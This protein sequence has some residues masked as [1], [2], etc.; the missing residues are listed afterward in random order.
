MKEQETT[1]IKPRVQTMFNAH[2]FN[3]K[4]EINH[5]PS[6]TIPDQTMPLKELIDRFTRGLPVT[7]FKPVY[8]EDNSLPDPRK[9]DIA[10]YNEMRKNV[11][12]ELQTLIEQK[13]QQELQNI[14]NQR[15]TIIQQ[16]V[17]EELAKRISTNTP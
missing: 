10:E 6:L 8:D 14:E 15:E 16:R 13:N 4:G 12:L 11:A 7:T 3:H 17:E 2:L 5:Q 9:M 1:G